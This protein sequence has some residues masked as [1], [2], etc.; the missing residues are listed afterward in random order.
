LIFRGFHAS[1]P[2]PLSALTRERGREKT[3]SPIDD[4]KSIYINMTLKVI[5]PR[6][7]EIAPGF[8]ELMKS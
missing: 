2:N 7:T 3:F 8:R 4:K 6:L 1:P 5:G